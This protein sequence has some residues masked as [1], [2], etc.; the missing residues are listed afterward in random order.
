M[1]SIWRTAESRVRESKHS[2]LTISESCRGTQL[3]TIDERLG[4]VARL[5]AGHR[6]R[7]GPP[8]V[9]R[10]TRP[11]ARI[12]AA[13]GVQGGASPEHGK[14]PAAGRPLVRLRPR[15]RRLWRRRSSRGRAWWRTRAR[16]GAAKRATPRLARRGR[17]DPADA[18]RG[19]RR[20]VRRVGRAV[21]PLVRGRGDH[22]SSNARDR[23]VLDS[24]GDASRSGSARDDHRGDSA[25]ELARTPR[26]R[27]PGAVATV[28]ARLSAWW[29][30]A[31]PACLRVD[32][33]LFHAPTDVT[34]CRRRFAC[35]R[36][37]HRYSATTRGRRR[38]RPGEPPRGPAAD[39]RVFGAAASRRRSSRP[40]ST[41]VRPK[42]RRVSPP[43][44]GRLDVLA[45][46][47]S[48]LRALRAPARVVRRRSLGG[49]VAAEAFAEANARR[50]R[51]GGDA[52]R[53]DER[54][55]RRAQ[56]RRSRRRVA[57]GSAVWASR[58]A[59]VVD[60]ARFIAP[61]ASCS[62][63]GVYVSGGWSRGA[64]LFGGAREARRASPPATR[65]VGSSGWISGQGSV[66]GPLL[67]A[68][69][70]SCHA[71]GSPV[72]PSPLRAPRPSRPRESP[73]RLAS[74]R[75]SG[76]G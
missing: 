62:G 11:I 33:V 73:C 66:R 27:R 37:T 26:E 1:S 67:A 12:A 40:A 47:G 38:G 45:P 21:L 74:S 76:V 51:A 28:A 24:R 39:A 18:R 35:R 64:R 5:R 65:R 54:R 57:S 14:P 58:A 61:R 68:P 9:E 63:H 69:G 17:Q 71:S 3:G 10:S 42:A 13:Q 43:A 75:W 72:F 44:D 20:A 56:R 36:L 59:A 41:A 32:R 25:R 50:R 31:C 52:G 55:R 30:S 70:R 8:S 15:R 19:R 2:V 60:A 48:E 29:R 22:A 34:H 6:R 49:D 46:S 4:A 16:A 23:H 7:A 53:S